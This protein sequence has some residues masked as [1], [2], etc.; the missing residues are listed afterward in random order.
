MLAETN[1]IDVVEPPCEAWAIIEIGGVQACQSTE[2]R[3]SLR[4]VYVYIL[5]VTSGLLNVE[6]EINLIPL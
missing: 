5:R 2:Y 3:V 6:Q 1:H 4:R